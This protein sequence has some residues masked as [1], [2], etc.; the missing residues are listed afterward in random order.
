[1]ETIF[2][3]LHGASYFG[4]IDFSDAY[5]QIGLDEEAKDIC[6][7]NT[8]QGLFKMCRLPQVLKNSSSIFQNCI[9]S[10]LKGIK[11]VVIFQDDVLVYGTT[12][13][14]FDKRMIAVKSRLRKKN[15]TNNEKKSNSKPVD[16]VSFLGYSISKERIAPDP[17]HVEKIKNA[18]APSNNNQLES[19]VGLANFC[20]RMRPDFATKMLHLNNMR[21]SDF[22]FSWGKMQQKTFEHIKNELCAKPLVQPYSLQKEATVTADASEKIIGG[23]LSQEGHPVIYVSRKLTPAEQNYSNIEREALAIVFVV[24]RLEQLLLGRRFTLQTDHKP[25]KYLFAPDEEIPKTASARIPRWA[26]ALMGFDYELKYTPG[27]Q[28]PMQ[29]L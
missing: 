15:F 3:N 8:S 26:I 16:S 14:Q 27:E 10:T 11:G 1:M 6:T 24:T 29:M 28:I 20:G 22:D 5:Y 13:E 4:K 2:H 12:K 7:I 21:N 9:E 19:F 25:L 18:K 17:K 23:V